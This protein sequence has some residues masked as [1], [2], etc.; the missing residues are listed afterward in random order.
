MR[1]SHSITDTNLMIK[2]VTTNIFDWFL[3]AFFGFSSVIYGTIM[4]TANN[5]TYNYAFFIPLFTGLM[6]L[7]SI[8][9]VKNLKYNLINII[10]YSTY[11][12]RNSLTPFVLF[13]AGYPSNI[14]LI[15]QT[16]INYTVL[17]MVLDTLVVF[18]YLL[19]IKN[20]RKSNKLKTSVSK[21]KLLN[22]FLLLGTL[23]SIYAYSTVPQIQ[24]GYVSLFSGELSELSTEIPFRTA[25]LMIYRLFILIFPMIQLLLP[26][27]L[28]YKIHSIFGEKVFSIFLSLI[29]SATPL[30]FV[31]NTSAFSFILVVTFFITLLEF[32]P[33]YRNFLFVLISLLSL[34]G[35]V[36]FFWRKIA[37]GSYEGSFTTVANFLQAYF[38]GINNI[39]GAFAIPYDLSK[40][41]IV[42][43]DFFSMIP[44]INTLFPSLKVYNNSTNSFLTTINLRGQILS[45]LSMAYLHVNILAPLINVII[46][47]VANDFYKNS[48]KNIYLYSTGVLVS[49]YFAITPIM[50]NFSILGFTFFSNLFLLLLFVKYISSDN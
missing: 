28:I 42:V 4:I 8:L 25:D 21:P 32:Y 30:L 1:K 49:I 27:K 43:R 12:I 20:I 37:D 46:I 5:I 33:S 44:F 40:P 22:I 11:Y 6:Y 48:R 7:F 23:F 31:G 19:T 47:K 29:I 45:N 36:F 35:L 41:S 10:I 24:N 38:P 13:L 15:N 2:S 26:I 17:L 39:A 9:F 18:T 50:Y 16:L 34:G 14:N 3:L